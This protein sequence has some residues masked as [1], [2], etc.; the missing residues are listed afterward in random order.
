MPSRLGQNISLCLLTVF[1]LAPSINYKGR[2]DKSGG[3][4]WTR[5]E[6]RKEIT[7]LKTR[8]FIENII[9]TFQSKI[10]YMNNYAILF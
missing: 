5:W 7:K 2:K 6:K 3:A 4:L 10:V 1:S 8:F 9:L